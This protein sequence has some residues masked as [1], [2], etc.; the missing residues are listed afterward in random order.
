MVSDPDYLASLDEGVAA[1]KRGEGKTMEEIM[2]HRASQGRGAKPRGTGG[3]P[4]AQR[5]PGGLSGASAMVSGGD[6]SSR[7]WVPDK[8]WRI[9]SNESGWRRC[10]DVSGRPLVHCPNMA[11]AEF[12]RSHGWWAYCGEHL[13]GRRIETGEVLVDVHPESPAAKQGWAG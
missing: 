1:I 5:R 11:V 3:H 8:R 4:Q 12:R 10:R 13:Y 7:V 2:D 9:R 6:A